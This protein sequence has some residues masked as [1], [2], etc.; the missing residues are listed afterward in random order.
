MP[1]MVPMMSAIFF[2]LPLISSIVA[3][4]CWITEPPRC[5]TSAADEASRSA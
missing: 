5:A 3:T 2:E 4:T 1:S